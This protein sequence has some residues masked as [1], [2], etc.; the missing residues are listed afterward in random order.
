MNTTT[1]ELRN[2]CVPDIHLISKQ[3]CRPLPFSVLGQTDPRPRL[4]GARGSQTPQ[5]IPAGP[6]VPRDPKGPHEAPKEPNGPRAL[7]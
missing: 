3:K 1:V 5:R 2:L 6:K 7:A 4:P